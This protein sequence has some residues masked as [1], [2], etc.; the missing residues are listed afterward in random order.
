VTNDSPFAFR[1]PDRGNYLVVIGSDHF[2]VTFYGVRGS[3]PCDGPEIARYGGN[4]S[5]VGVDVPGQ[6]PIMLDIGTGSRYYG[7]DYPVDELYDG[8]CLIT[9]LHWDHVLGLPFF[10]PALRPGAKLAL[11]APVQESGQDLASAL[12]SMWCPPSFPITIDDLPGAFSFHEHGDDEFMI[13]DVRVMSRLVPHIGNTLGYR[14]EWGGRSVAYLSDHQQPA[15]SAYTLADGAREL[16]E[17]VDMLIHDAQF[18]PEEFATK[19]HWG[20]CTIEYAVWVAKECGVG[21][22]VLFHH[23]PSHDDDT[24]DRLRDQAAGC[25]GGVVNVVSAAEGL[26][27]TVGA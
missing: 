19:A 9:H 3:T 6:Q 12:R 23:D 25:F 20:H 22:A 17:G 1:H 7:M 26:T 27:L 16:C 15:S 18:T 13:G 5:C 10:P 24:L 4:T 14:L 11:H 21:T 2:T 8:T